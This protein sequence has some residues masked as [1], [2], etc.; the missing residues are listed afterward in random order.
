LLTMMSLVS[1]TVLFVVFVPARLDR[2]GAGEPA[3][4]ATNAFLRASPAYVHPTTPMP[5]AGPSTALQRQTGA[6]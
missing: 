3:M 4:L 5:L 6:V 1:G 2:K